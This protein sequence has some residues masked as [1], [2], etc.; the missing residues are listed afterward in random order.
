MKKSPRYVMRSISEV[1]RMF[2][3]FRT[4]CERKDEGGR[5]KDESDRFILPPSS[6]ILLLFPFMPGLPLFKDTGDHLIQR[7]VL[8][9][10]VHHGVTVEN[11]R[12]RFCDAVAIY[13]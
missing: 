13:L 9:A 6:F 1:R 5:M 2:Q 11:R 4:R 10:H 7:R 3:Y 8:H 12:Q